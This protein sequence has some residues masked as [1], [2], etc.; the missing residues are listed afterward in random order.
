MPNREMGRTKL[1]LTTWT[2]T[3]T[4]SPPSEIFCRIRSL[5]HATDGSTTLCAAATKPPS[6]ERISSTISSM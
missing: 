6:C 2:R 1:N 3:T 5:Y 4:S